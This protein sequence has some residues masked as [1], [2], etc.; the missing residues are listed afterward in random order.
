MYSGPEP[1][2]GGVRRPPLAEIAPHCTQFDGEMST[3]TSP[4]SPSA[5]TA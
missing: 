4:S 5:P 3:V 2:S 1:P